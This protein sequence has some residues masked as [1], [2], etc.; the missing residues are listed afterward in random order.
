MKRLLIVLFAAASLA[1]SAGIAS[2]ATSTGT[3][4]VSASVVQACTLA[5]TNVAFPQYAS[6][7]A[8]VVNA[9]GNVAIT[10]GSG[11]PYTYTLNTGLQPSGA[12][13]RMTDTVSFLNYGLYS[14]AGYSIL[15]TNTSNPTSG[16]GTVQNFILYGQ[17]PGAQSG[18]TAGAYT[19]TVTVSV[20][21]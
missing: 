20:T 21:W 13:T 14:D 5:T 6:G 15:A 17:V 9:N 18:L 11:V 19:D 8:A 2:A 16:T 10:C 7:Q 4:G 1:F 3:V 12:Q